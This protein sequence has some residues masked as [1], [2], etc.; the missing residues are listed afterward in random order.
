ML[1]D[2]E[3]VYYANLFLE[4]WLSSLFTREVYP[5]WSNIK[6]YLDS[7]HAPCYSNLVDRVAYEIARCIEIKS[8][9]FSIRYRMG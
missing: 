8:I 4:Y 5:A 9:S 7:V 3:A 1:Y 2:S 6:E